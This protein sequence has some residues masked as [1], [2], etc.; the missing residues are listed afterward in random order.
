MAKGTGPSAEDTL[1]AAW[2]AVGQV[3]LFG[4]LGGALDLSLISTSVLG[5]AVGVILLALPFRC[6]AAYY[7]AAAGRWSVSDRLFTAVSW[8]PK[9]T[10]QAALSTVALQFVESQEGSYSSE[11]AYSQDWDR[12][13]IILAAATLSIV[14][15]APTGAVAI[16]WFGPRLLRLPDGPSSTFSGPESPDADAEPERPLQFLAE[17][18]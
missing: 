1:K 9:A 7:C 4:F 11:E 18:I 16:E 12:S 6:V 14:L 2:L 15:T 5:K 17:A 13:M 8:L 3:Y 10:V